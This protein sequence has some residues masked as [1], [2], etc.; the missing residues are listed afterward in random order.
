MAEPSTQH[1]PTVVPRSGNLFREGQTFS[2]L[3]P[4][5]HL[6]PPPTRRRNWSFRTHPWNPQLDA[7][8]KNSSVIWPV[9]FFLSAAP[10]VLS[11]VALGVEHPQVTP[12]A[13]CSFCISLCLLSPSGGLWLPGTCSPLQGWLE[14]LPGSRRS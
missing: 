5:C 10:T 11:P 14:Q 2:L 6:S 12:G 13:G 9:L 7:P 3:C 8:P 1:S 4:F